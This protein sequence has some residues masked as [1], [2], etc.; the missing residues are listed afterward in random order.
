MKLHTP[1]TRPIVFAI[2]LCLSAFIKVHAKKDNEE[3]CFNDSTLYLEVVE[4]KPSFQ[5]N[6]FVEFGGPSLS[7][8][9]L[10][11]DSRF[12]PGSPFGY[13][14]GMAYV[15]G[16]LSIG[17]YPTLDF[18]GVNLPLELNAIFGKHKSKFEIGI[19]MVPSIL[20][21]ARWSYE[22]EIIKTEY[23]Y[24]DY[25]IISHRHDEGT[26]INITGLMNIGYR[27]QRDSGFFMRVGLTLMLGDLKCSPVDGLMLMPNIAFG[28]TI[29]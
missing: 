8:F 15:D 20:H 25:N 22:Y 16:S 18:K 23:N 10:G 12:K 5:R 17:D 13:R 4:K 3:I 2:M 28:Y 27:Y 14:A 19:G 11:F 1:L 6:F 26:R 24:Y 9:G 21:R 7:V 29:R